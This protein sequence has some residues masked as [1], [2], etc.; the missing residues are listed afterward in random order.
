MKT[1]IKLFGIIA[2]VALIGFCLTACDDE[3]T[4][5]PAGGGGAMFRFSNGIIEG[6]NSGFEHTTSISIPSTINGIPVTRI[7]RAAFHGRSLA[8]VQIPNTVTYIEGWAF[9]AN[10]L[11]SIQI[12]NSVTYI[13][14]NAFAGNNLSSVQI[15][16]SVTNIGNFVFSNNNNPT[17]VTIPFATPE[18]ATMAFGRSV[19]WGLDVYLI[20]AP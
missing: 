19:L 9:A 7:G 11:S 18:D 8:S 10:N 15:P 12:P 4:S 1:K 16:N 2:V 5:S 6:F 20:F 13:G 14:V 17:S 3:G